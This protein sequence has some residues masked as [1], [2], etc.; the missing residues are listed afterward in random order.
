MGDHCNKQFLERAV[1]LYGLR[2]AGTSLVHNLLDGGSQLLMLP[3]EI[4]VNYM[5]V[6]RKTGVPADFPAA[7][8][9]KGRLDFPCLLDI[10][11]S[12]PADITPKSSYN[13]E[14]L[15]KE[16]TNAVLDTEGYVRRLATILD[17]G[18]QNYA[19]LVRHDVA[20]FAASLRGEAQRDY[21]CWAAKE[22]GGQSERLVQFHREMFPQGKVVFIARQPQFVVRSIICDRRRKGIAMTWR[23]VWFECYK[24]QGL[25]NF[26]A[27]QRQ[28][29]K[30]SDTFVA[31]E[32]LT[33]NPEKEMHRVAQHLEIPYEPIFCEPTALGQKV[34][35][36]TSS[37]KTTAVFRQE[38][39]WKKDLNARELNAMAVFFRIAPLVFMRKGKK[40]TPYPA[41]RRMIQA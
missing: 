35:V 37:Q 25:I 31:Y 9:R 5:T 41:L 16:Q 36:R 32:T 21:S 2:K 8:L 26:L 11:G 38:S 10:G 24:A 20:S 12:S 28:A 17:G 13:I 1:L 18:P 6:M 40:L 4:K 7:Y 15:T 19:E 29:G 22:V 23:N 33:E 3:G 39:N 14:G 34:V 27:Q 30:N